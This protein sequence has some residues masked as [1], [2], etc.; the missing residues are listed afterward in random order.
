MW[1]FFS[2]FFFK[3]PEFWSHR[4]KIL[5]KKTTLCTNIRPRL[6]VRIIF[7]ST[8]RGQTWDQG[9]DFLEELE[10]VTVATTPYFEHTALLTYSLCMEVPKAKRAGQKSC[11]K[12]CQITMY[13]DIF[14]IYFDF[15]N[16]NLI[17][18]I[19]LLTWKDLDLTVHMRRN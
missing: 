5:V 6:A 15:Q 7:M 11:L 17:D 10:S 14:Y 8:W 19:C 2:F 1:I 12:M 4:V 9:S 18:N 3:K 16:L 13:F